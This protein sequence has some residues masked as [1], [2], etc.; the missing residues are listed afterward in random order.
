MKGLTPLQRFM[1][2]ISPEPNSGCWLW[3]SAYVDHRYGVMWLEGGN[4]YAHR[5]SFMLHNGDIPAGMHVCHKCDNP[6]CVNPD[7]LF[8]GNA[9]DNT[10]DCIRKKRKAGQTLTVEQVSEIKR[11]LKNG[12]KQTA[13]VKEYGTTLKAIGAIARGTS[14]RNVE[15]AA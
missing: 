7:H 12:E 8:L 1:N 9:K 10:Q 14:W 13:L 6:A 15:A 4:K 2:F 3:D 5:I 11:R